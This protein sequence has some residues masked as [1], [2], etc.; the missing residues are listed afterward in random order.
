MQTIGLKKCSSK[1]NI[2][3]SH[4]TEAEGI[5]FLMQKIGPLNYE[6]ARSVVFTLIIVD[7]AGHDHGDWERVEGL[8]HRPLP[9]PRAG[10]LCQGVQP[11]SETQNGF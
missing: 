1:S 6:V 7:R 9:H 8:P 3:Y 5:L 2:T 4:A 10:H 11:Y